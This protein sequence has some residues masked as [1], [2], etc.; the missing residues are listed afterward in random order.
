MAQQ[1]EPGTC[2]VLPGLVAACP[3]R[4]HAGE[5]LALHG[6]QTLRLAAMAALHLHPECAGCLTPNGASP[7]GLVPATSASTAL[8]PSSPGGQAG[9]AAWGEHSSCSTWG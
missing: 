7:A 5:A 9:H 6:E 1:S 3:A 8:P 2:W 4:Q